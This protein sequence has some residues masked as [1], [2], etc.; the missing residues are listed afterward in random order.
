[1]FE[2]LVIDDDPIVRAV[3]KRT[4][5][6]QGYNTTAV[7][8]GEEGIKQAKQIRPAL[9]VCDWMMSPVDGI[10]VC[11]MIK[12][13]PDLSTTF[14]VLLTAKGEVEDRVMGLDA[15]ADEFLS[16]PIDM[17]ELRARVRAGLRLHQLNEDLRSQK[18]AV[19]ALNQKLR[20]ELDEA[21]EYVRSLLP[22]PYK[23]TTVT[24]DTLFK[25]SAELGGDCFDYYKLDDDNLVIYLLD[26]SGHGVGSALMSISA[27]NVMRSRSVRA[28]QSQSLRA[29]FSKPSQVLTALNDAFQMT[30]HG[31][32]YFT[33]WYGVYNQTTRQLV[34]ATAGHP[35]GILLHQTSD[36]SIQV[37]QLGE[38]G[39]PV[40]MLEES[41]FE[42]SEMEIEPDSTLYIFSDGA[43]EI[44]ITEDRIWGLN[45]FI[46]LLTECQKTNNSNLE[47]VLEQIQAA[48]STSAFEDDLSVLKV[49]FA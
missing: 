43:Y 18:R 34:Y 49:N 13:E 32:K 22:S 30:E 42:D 24:I 45:P 9:I 41:F 48:T 26:V 14:F 37:K 39:L 6:K 19:D 20:S 1:M 10:E 35:P 36:T 17:N 25:P 46:D 31:D 8:N 4:L 23:D 16:K 11:R 47:Q 29:N 44:H 15:G 3:L 21:A 7:G 38:P 28:A 5:Q 33:M 2:I 27:L 40:G 12:A